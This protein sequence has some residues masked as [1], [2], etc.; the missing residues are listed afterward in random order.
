MRAQLPARGQETLPWLRQPGGERGGRRW[1]W[2]LGLSAVAHAVLAGLVLSA[3]TPERARVLTPYVAAAPALAELRPPPPPPPPP[4]PP[5]PLPLAIQPAAPAPEPPRQVQAP[6]RPRPQ[7]PVGVTP[8]PGPGV[9]VD[10]VKTPDGEP[11]S[12]AAAPAGP[13]AAEAPSPPAEPAH[14]VPVRAAACAGGAAWARN[15]AQPL[16]DCLD[17]WE[18]HSPTCGAAT[19]V[20]L[21]VAANGSWRSPPQVLKSCGFSHADAALL[22]AVA[23]CAPL[24]PPPSNCR[25]V[26]VDVPLRF[27]EP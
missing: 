18:G 16:A 6:R 5:P 11:A 27:A 4:A 3:R 19:V 14:E 8:Q 22:A 1:L 9:A 7:R 26:V 10:P 21:S 23:T 24:P 13:D 17:R 20:R 15:L 25:A 12:A 2:A